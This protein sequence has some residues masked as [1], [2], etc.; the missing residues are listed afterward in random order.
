MRDFLGNSTSAK[1]IFSVGRGVRSLSISIG[2]RSLWVAEIIQDGEAGSCARLA[3]FVYPPDITLED[4]GGLGGELASFLSLQN[5]SARRVV[6]GVPAKW[7]IVRPYDMPPADAQTT[8][9]VLWLHATER[10][11]PALGP[12]V[13]DFLGQSSPTE[14]TTLLL[15]GLQ[16]RWIERL[17]ALAKAARL[18]IIGIT[19]IGAVVGAVASRHVRSSLIALF[20][21]GGL[22]VIDQEDGHIRS[23]HY[24]RSNGSAQPVIASLRRSVAA[25]SL[26]EQSQNHEQKDLVIWNDIGMDRAFLDALQPG[27]GLSITEVQRNWVALSHLGVSEGAKGLSAIAL[28]ERGRAG[29]R[30]GVDFLHPRLAPPERERHRIPAAWLSWAVVAAILIFI[31]ACIDILSLQKQVNGLDN[32]LQ[33]MDPALQ[34]ARPYLDSMQ[35]AESFRTTHPRYLACI[36]DLTEA[37]PPDRQTYLTNFNLHADMS[38]EISGIST[39]EQNI[40]NFRDKLTSTGRFSDLMCRLDARE[41]HAGSTGVLFSVTFAYQP[42]Q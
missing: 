25:L 19:P 37:L 5:F 22:E 35:F 31:A 18:K 15:M 36:A 4:P 2:E 1:S 30:L 11:M 14:P 32:Q 20:G 8:S 9:S 17:A 24:V 42:G 40:L 10:I 21:A 12:M 27:T 38:G 26:D 13:F 39:N 3:E 41:T 28:G 7:L 23:I 6:V 34:V 33:S 29:A 16:T